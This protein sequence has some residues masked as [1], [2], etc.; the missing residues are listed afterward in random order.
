[1]IN[2]FDNEIIEKNY[3]NKA[4]FKEYL[5][6]RYQLVQNSNEYIQNQAPRIKRK[7][8]STKQSAI[9]D[10]EMLLRMVKNLTLLSSPIMTNGFKKIKNIF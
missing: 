3:L 10:L 7:E 5:Q 4:Q 1:M 6:D 9:E 2:G 8:E